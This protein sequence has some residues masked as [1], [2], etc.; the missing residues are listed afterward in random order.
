M[1]EILKSTFGDN[2][3]VK[4]QT[5]SGFFCSHAGGNLVQ[6]CTDC[7]IAGRDSSVGTATR[8]ML[9]GL[10]IESHWGRVIFSLL[11]RPALGP[12]QSPGSLPGVKSLGHSI[13]TQPTSSAKVKEKVE[14][15]LYS[16]S[17]PS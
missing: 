15:Y 3:M 11:S 17:G 12:T 8:Y 4:T 1:R 13:A 6:Y 9:D 10:R 14:L 7:E 2:V 5:L 16:P